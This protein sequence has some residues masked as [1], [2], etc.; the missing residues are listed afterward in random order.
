MDKFKIGQKE[1]IRIFRQEA[2]FDRACEDAY[3]RALIRF[4]M[5]EDGYAT[6]VD[7]WERT[8]CSIRLCFTGYAMHDSNHVY[9]FLAWVSKEEDSEGDTSSNV[10]HAPTEHRD[11]F[12]LLRMILDSSADRETLSAPED[13]LVEALCERIGYGAVM[14]SAARQWRRKDPVGAF[15]VGPCIGSVEAA[16]RSYQQHAG[17]R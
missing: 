12:H 16:V 14:D 6:R 2:G 15:L 7:G 4:G 3:T 9:S 5:D 1:E 8:T 17:D 11:L 10:H 13:E